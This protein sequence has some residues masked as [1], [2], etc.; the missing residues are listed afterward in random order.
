MQFTLQILRTGDLIAMERLRPVPDVHEVKT[1]AEAVHP[2]NDAVARFHA[3]DHSSLGV[4]AKIQ[5]LATSGAEARLLKEGSTGFPT[6]IVVCTSTM[7]Q[8]SVIC[9]GARSQFLPSD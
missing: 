7:Q 6:G 1:L 3:L 4:L 9:V 2:I 8:L 5:P